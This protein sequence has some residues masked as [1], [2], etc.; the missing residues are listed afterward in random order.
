MTSSA[1]VGAADNATIRILFAMGRE[2]VLPSLFSVAS[3][4]AVD[5]RGH[6]FEYLIGS[7]GLSVM[8]IYL[9]V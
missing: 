1:S 8:L 9:A 4:L 6:T 5:L 3:R 2:R 7:A